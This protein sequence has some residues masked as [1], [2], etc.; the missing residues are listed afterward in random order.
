MSELEHSAE[1][2]LPERRTVTALKK[3]AS[4]C[5]GCELYKHATQTVF[6]RGSKNASMLT[7]PILQ[8]QSGLFCNF[9]YSRK[10]LCHT[11]QPLICPKYQK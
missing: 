2:Y 11:M 8:M 5:E 7:R 1:Q 4:D 6:G 3:A 9:C 10:I